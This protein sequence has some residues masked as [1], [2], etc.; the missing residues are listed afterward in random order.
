[1]VLMREAGGVRV[2]LC[3]WAPAPCR[4]GWRHRADAGTWTALPILLPEFR[5]GRG[6]RL[7]ALI[8]GLPA[9]HPAPLPASH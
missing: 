6:Q 8:P 2:V 4:W 1:V 7:E 3:S 5:E 9:K